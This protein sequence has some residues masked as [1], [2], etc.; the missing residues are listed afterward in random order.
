M[1]TS[2]KQKPLRKYIPSEAYLEGMKTTGIM[3]LKKAKTLS[4]AYLEGMKTYNAGIF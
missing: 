3:S 2:A 4:E 1:K